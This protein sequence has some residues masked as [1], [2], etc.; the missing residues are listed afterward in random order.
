[1]G[2]PTQQ[3]SLSIIA[4]A[5]RHD[6]SLTAFLVGELLNEYQP[7]AIHTGPIERVL[8]LVGLLLI[9][10]PKINSKS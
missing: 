4:T 9:T 6:N 1:M 8:L 5:L 2:D 3:I 10:T 7:S